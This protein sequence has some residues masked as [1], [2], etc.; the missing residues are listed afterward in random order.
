MK[1]CGFHARFSRGF[2]LA[3]LAAALTLSGLRPALAGW[4]FSY[5]PN[6]VKLDSG[7]RDNVFMVG[8]PL[9]FTLSIA[10]YGTYN[11]SGSVRYEVRDYWGTVVDQG[12]TSAP[13][14]R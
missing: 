7:K 3:C 10:N 4:L 6:M 11:L 5:P 12:N 14:D 1:F 13:S 9:T 2:L 8:D